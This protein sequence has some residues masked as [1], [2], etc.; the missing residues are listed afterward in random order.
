MTTRYSPSISPLAP[1]GTYARSVGRP[2]QGVP[3]CTCQ[4]CRTA[5]NRY[6]KRRRILNETGR[7]LRVPA[8]PAADHVRHLISIGVGW[9]Y[10]IEESGCSSCTLH[11]LI[12][13]QQTTKRSVADRILAVRPEPQPYRLVPALAS[14]RRLRALLALGH[15]IQGQNSICEHSGVDQTVISEVIAG[16]RR[17]LRAD[18]VE[19][20]TRAYGVLADQRG[21]YPRNQRRA[22]SEGWATPD[23]WD[24][25]TLEDPGFVPATRPTPRSVVL[26]EN[27]HELVHVQGHTWEHAALRLGVKSKNSLQVAYYRWLRE[28]GDQQEAA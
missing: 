4:P 17:T 16:H 3:G 5:R 21:N 14:T 9:K 28:C 8:Q 7:T 13:G 22:E 23:Y 15:R 27:A 6:G 20:I 25:D 2:A 12:H 24:P 18:T 19:H 26:G 10:I 1:H 11:R